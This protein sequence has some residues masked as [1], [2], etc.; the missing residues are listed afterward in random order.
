MGNK[1]PFFVTLNRF[2]QHRL[3]EESL[4]VQIEIL[5][6]AQNDKS[7]CSINSSI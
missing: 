1:F 7:R 3:R 2:S 6:F 5:P 4:I